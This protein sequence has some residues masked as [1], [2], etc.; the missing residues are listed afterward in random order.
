[1][2]DYPKGLRFDIYERLTLS[3]EVAGIGELEDI[4]LVPRITMQTHHDQ[5]VL[6]GDLLLMGTYVGVDARNEV[7]GIK[8]L[9][10]RIPVEITLPLKRIKRMDSIGIEIENFDVELI[11]ARSLNIT[12]VIS[13]NGIDTAAEQA[14]KQQ[15]EAVFVHEA[16]L[17]GDER[18]QAEAP[19]QEAASAADDRGQ[20][21]Q[22]SAVDA[23][24]QD[25][26]SSVN[27]QAIESAAS[28][29]PNAAA[30][31]SLSREY[32]GIEQRQDRVEP[33][34]EVQQE[35]KPEKQSPEVKQEPKVESK[36]EEKTE[37][38]AGA[39][40]ESKVE[41]KAEEK[42]GAKLEPKVESKAEEKTEAKAETKAHDLVMPEATAEANLEP[43]SETKPDM[44][45]NIEAD[46]NN[47]PYADTKSEVQP[48]SHAEPEKLKSASEDLETKLHAE[49]ESRLEE[50]T[51]NEATIEAELLGVE[52][53]SKVLEQEQPK[54]MKIAFGSNKQS[55]DDWS[56]AAAGVKSLLNKQADEASEREPAAVHEAEASAD[57]SEPQAAE[58]AVRWKNLL[59]S[60]EQEEQ[61]FSKMRMCIVQK[62]ET[63]DTIASRYSL[64]P[65]EIVLYNR[66]S[67]D[68]VQEGQVIYIP[69]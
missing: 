45:A 46:V 59:L 48:I 62:E 20:S 32:A 7:S 37:A 17:A 12:G 11:S 30:E 19:L 3:D 28:T 39:K 51:L 35:A 9:S 54:E 21:S 61:R 13:L 5:A 63:L 40:V 34:T 56:G 24:G 57:E 15:G 66:L 50:E 44:K 42:A 6:S 16:D 64:N 27:N 38:K 60:T 23:P 26:A 55:T 25:D 10:H 43:L 18:Q 67:S 47:K 29:D 41:S 1:V 22:D 33:V 69:S 52:E 4:E 31:H 36:A 14:W 68:H 49:G 53:E 58:D 2:S 65:K 8:Q